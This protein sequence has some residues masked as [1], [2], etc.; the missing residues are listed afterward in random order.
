MRKSGY[1]YKMISQEIPTIATF[2]IQ[3][4]LSLNNHLCAHLLN[5]YA[6]YPVT[7]DDAAGAFSFCAWVSSPPWAS[8]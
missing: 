4:Q 1:G 3:V 2:G 5:V 6:H 7:R 8:L